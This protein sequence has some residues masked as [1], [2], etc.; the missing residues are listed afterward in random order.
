MTSIHISRLL[1]LLPLA[2]IT[3][4]LAGCSNGALNSDEYMERDEAMMEQDGAMMQA[5]NEA[6]MKQDEVLMQADDATMMKG[7]DTMM[8]STSQTS[9]G[10][11]AYADT[12]FA[13]L[14]GDEPVILFFHAS[15]CPTCRTAD[16][17]ISDQI[18]NLSGTVLKV[19]YDNAAELKKEYAITSQHTFVFF[20]A[21]GSVAK[22]NL[23]GGFA[24]AQAFF[25]NTL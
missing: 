7:D 23:G 24:E 16:Q 17:D 22:K 5:D 25:D 9:G 2:L 6:V 20:N 10:Y 11:I 18:A 15:W 12:T 21:D 1:S 13:R 8:E 4:T 19:D 14:R 3:I